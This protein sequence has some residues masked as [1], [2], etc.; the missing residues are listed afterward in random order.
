[1]MTRYAMIGAAV[2]LSVAGCD[3]ATSTA[4]P[5]SAPTPSS[6]VPAATTTAAAATPTGS[7]AAAPARTALPE[8]KPLS[9][10]ERKQHEDRANRALGGGREQD[11]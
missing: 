7:T 11:R 10:A 2:A 4:P 8:L 1:M 9:A 5:A 3:P 6:A